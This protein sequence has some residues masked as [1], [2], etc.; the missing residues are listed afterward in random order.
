MAF[1]TAYLDETQLRDGLA[2][3]VTCNWVINLCPDKGAVY[4]EA[5]RILK[6]GGRLAVA[7]IVYIERVDPQVLERSQST[8]A[9]CLGGTIAEEDY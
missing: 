6:P 3:V 2:D 8:W 1:R 4:R 5:F 7:D 9:G